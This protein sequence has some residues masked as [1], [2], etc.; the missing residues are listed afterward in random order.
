MYASRSGLVRFRLSNSSAES[1]LSDYSVT[2]YHSFLTSVLV[3]ASTVLVA[4]RSV[5]CAVVGA[6]SVTLASTNSAAERIVGR[7]MIQ[8]LAMKSSIDVEVDYQVPG[9]GCHVELMAPSS[10]RFALD[11]EN[12]RIHGPTNQH[13]LIGD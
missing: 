2:T 1:D 7:C 11:I 8:I 10:G 12:P 4:R 9:N 5:N 3:R 6:A 13:G